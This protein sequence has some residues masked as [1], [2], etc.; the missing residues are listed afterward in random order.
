LN[1]FV[2]FLGAIPL[3]W[4]MRPSR[5]SQASLKFI[6]CLQL[7]FVPAFAHSPAGD[8]A[9]A[10]KNFMATLTPEQRTKTVFELKDDERL[11][12][13]FVPKPRKGLP[14]KEMTAAQRT[15][16]HALLASGL[17][18]RGYAKASTIMSLEQILFDLEDKS[19]RR[20]AELYYVTIF[21]TPGA[22]AW[23]WRVEG[24]HL[25]LNFTVHGENVLAVTPSFFGANPAQ[26]REGPRKGLRTLSHEEDRARE[27]A[28]SLNPEQRK[29]GIIAAEA[30]RDIITGSS[31][32]ASSQ[33]PL[34][35]AAASLTQ[36]QKVLLLDLLKEYV[37]RYRTELAEADLKKISQ[38]GDDK[39]YFAWAGG[40]EQGQGHY[41]RIQGPT[42]LMEY[43]NTQD[44]AN[45]IH[46][47]WRDLEKDFGGDPLR[48]HYE[49]TPHAK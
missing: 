46:T 11:N 8:M 43:D 22:G 25:S 20:D 23:A 31:R 40:L 44:N 33:E 26:V 5:F 49:T 28:K 6:F 10:A 29:T 48:A 3:S 42:F 16:A 18:H 12:W 47:V 35:I 9:E 2:A 14:F 19:P 45:H 1:N 4:L 7:L 27:L 36:S 15:L 37:H 32:K 38:R 24:H 34:G 39:L 13:H 21:G 17:S 30:P 41:Y